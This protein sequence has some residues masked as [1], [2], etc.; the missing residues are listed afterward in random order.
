MVT[1]R[2][3]GTLRLDSKRACVSVEA[4]TVGELLDRTAA[5]LGLPDARVLRRSLI[6]VNGEQV[7]SLQTPLADGDEVYL[8]PPSAGG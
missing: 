3:F 8:L 7:R 2:L 1:V 5:E 6:F 4:R